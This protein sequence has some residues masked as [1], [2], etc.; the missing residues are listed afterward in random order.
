MAGQRGAY[1]G[2]LGVQLD[3]LGPNGELLTGDGNQILLPARSVI[4]VDQTRETRTIAEVDEPCLQIPER[5]VN[6]SLIH[7]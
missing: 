1:R 6:L 5:T 2:V 3:R 7:I 4:D